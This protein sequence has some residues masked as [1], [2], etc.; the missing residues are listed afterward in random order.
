MKNVNVTINGYSANGV[1]LDGNTILFTDPCKYIIRETILAKGSGECVNILVTFRNKP[2]INGERMIERASY[3]PVN[4][5]GIDYGDADH[6][7]LITLL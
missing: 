3:D 2:V 5:D 7:Y 6:S 4:Q 1:L